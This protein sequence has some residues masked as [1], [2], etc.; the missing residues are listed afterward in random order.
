MACLLSTSAPALNMGAPTSLPPGLDLGLIMGSAHMHGFEQQ[1]PTKLF[2]GGLTRFTTTK[3]LRDHFSRYGRLLDVVAMRQPDGRPRGFGYVT[4]ETRASAEAVLLEPQVVDGRVVDI[5][6][7]VP[8][9]TKENGS[10]LYSP[11]SAGGAGNKAGNSRSFKQH[12]NQPQPQPQ[13][14]PAQQPARQAQAS[15][16][17]AVPLLCNPWPAPPQFYMQ[18]PQRN[19]KQQSKQQSKDDIL[20]ATAPPGIENRPS[21]ETELSAD[22]LEFVPAA[23]VGEKKSMEKKPAPV[24]AV[25][26]QKESTRSRA[27]LGELTNLQPEESAADDIKP[28][29]IALGASANVSL[30]PS[31]PKDTFEVFTDSE[32]VKVKEQVYVDPPEE[33]EEA[34]QEETLSVETPAEESEA[35]ADAAEGGMPVSPS[36]IASIETSASGTSQKKKLSRREKRV[37]KSEEDAA[38]HALQGMPLS[39][40]GQQLSPAAAAAMLWGFDPANFLAASAA[41]AAAMN[42]QAPPGLALPAGG[43][44]A[45]PYGQVQWQPEAEASPSAAGPLSTVPV[46][47]QSIAAPPGIAAPAA[48]K[49]SL[50]QVTTK[51]N[52]PAQVTMATQTEESSFAGCIRCQALS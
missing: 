14:Q 23:P 52:G 26:S 20:C 12:Q 45:G 3:Q 6:L 24:G 34:P 41:A 43:A 49:G 11:S 2:I 27:P 36:S 18:Q 39:P 21:A 5:K 33:K 4:F 15:G 42:M 28:M 1:T 19:K 32:P 47:G 9:A 51:K 25:L 40:A 38:L 46:A 50:L 37:K 44:G 31:K 30:M 17:P 7:A 22:A 29:K 10:D 48:K 16:E 8:D 35:P 13:Q